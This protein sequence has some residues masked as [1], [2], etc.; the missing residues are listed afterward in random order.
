MKTVEPSGPLKLSKSDTF[1]KKGS[2]GAATV[3]LNV[4]NDIA[5]SEPDPSLSDKVIEAVPSCPAEGVTVM[6]H[7]VPVPPANVKLEPVLGMSVVSLLLAMTCEHDRVL[8]SSAIVKLRGPVV[9]S[10]L[11]T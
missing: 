6:V 1:E 7:A 9:L 5:L 8:L 2:R 4:L 3:T 11:M 10:S